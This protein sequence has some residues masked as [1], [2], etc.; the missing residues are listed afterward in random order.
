MRVGEYNRSI[1]GLLKNALD[2]LSRPPSGA[3]LTGKPV[4]IIGASPGQSGTRRAQA[5]L[6][7]GPAAMG[8]VVLPSPTMFL[9]EAAGLFDPEGRL[10]DEPTRDRV[11]ALLSAFH[12]WMHHQG[13]HH[14]TEVVDGA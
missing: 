1:P 12:C 11:K 8:A 4:A 6:R 9:S 14:P 2:W 5:A 3:A 10:V 13:C 7:Q